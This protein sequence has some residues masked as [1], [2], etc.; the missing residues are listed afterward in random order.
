MADLP[1]LTFWK[2][3]LQQAAARICRLA[4]PVVWAQMEMLHVVPSVASLIE[5]I[6]YGA[7]EPYAES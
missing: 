6:C 2:H 7:Q 5:A 4:G 1:G 3:A